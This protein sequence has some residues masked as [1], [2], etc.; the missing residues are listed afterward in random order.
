MRHPSRTGARR[1][2]ARMSNA[3]LSSK[4]V[5]EESEPS[6]RGIAGA[7]ISVAGAVGLTERGPIG[8]AVRCTS[9]P[10]YQKRFGRILPGSDV[11]LAALGFFSNGGGE[12]WVVRT[13][14]YDD[15]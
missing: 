8:K 2:D 3:L 4:V 12:L 13:A 15:V 9:L 10:D 6:V 11:S 5:V 7:P 1:G 14:H